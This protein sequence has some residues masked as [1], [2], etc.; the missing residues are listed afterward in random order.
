M[1]SL[2]LHTRRQ[3]FRAGQ[4]CKAQGMLLH[5]EGGAA[6][7]RLLVHSR[8][9]RGAPW[10][11]ATARQD[12]VA[13]LR[14]WRR[15]GSAPFKSISQHRLCEGL[16]SSVPE[17]YGSCLSA[18]FHILAIRA[19][20]SILNEGPLHSSCGLLGDRARLRL[21]SPRP[22]NALDCQAGLRCTA[23]SGCDDEKGGIPSGQG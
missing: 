6:S 13:Q 16:V 23:G 12:L 15:G 7:M 5:E 1:M 11:H 19:L 2:Q 3:W 18:P 9:M 22:I 14:C 8:S 20:F 17:W 10:Q 4:P 21:F